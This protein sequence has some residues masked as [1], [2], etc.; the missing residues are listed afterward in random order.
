MHIQDISV[1]RVNMPLDRPY[2]L[3]F[4]AVDMAYFDAIVVEVTTS[5]ERTGWGE[6]TILPG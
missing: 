4:N 3:S 6:V 5:D 2:P 1:Y